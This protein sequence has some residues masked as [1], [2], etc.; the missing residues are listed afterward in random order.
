MNNTFNLHRSKAAY[1][2]LALL[3]LTISFA[4]AFKLFSRPQDKSRL[5]TGPM[6][7]MTTTS[8]LECAVKEIGR[9]HVKVGVLITPGSCPGHYDISPKDLRALSTSQ[10]LF[11]HGYEGFVP[12]IMDSLGS[13]K[14]KQIPIKTSGNWMLPSNY[15]IALGQVADALRTSD[16]IH[17]ADYRKSLAG[18]EVKYKQLDVDLKRRIRTAGVEGIRV[19]CSDQQTEVA[20]WMGLFV[21]DT[22]PRAEEFTPVLLHYMTEIGR[23]NNVRLCIDNLQSS[24]TAGKELAKDIGAAHVTLSNFPGGFTG[25]DTWSNCMQDNV[26]RI[27]RE[28]GKR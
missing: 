23:K 25:T 28:I 19:L 7:I 21:V 5:G 22:Y 20:K 18:M 4:L 9:S 27:I 2:V 11:T 6:E 8:L 16:P 26:N 13:R 17:A 3:L 24:P 15:V 14:P 10:V 12:K 1:Y